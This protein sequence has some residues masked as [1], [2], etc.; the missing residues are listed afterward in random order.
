M[1]LQPHEWF[2]NPASDDLE[3]WMILR[4]TPHQA[5][6]LPK[7]ISFQKLLFLSSLPLNGWC[8]IQVHTSPN[9]Q[10]RPLPFLPTDSC[11]MLWKY[12]RLN[13][14]V[15]MFSVITWMFETEKKGH[16]YLE[17]LIWIFADIYFKNCFISH[18]KAPEIESSLCNV[19]YS[20]T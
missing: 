10:R 3:K 19:I 20:F 15:P 16:W 4:L 13:A 14:T 8:G 17:I 11:S 12:F 18:S 1:T 5:T 6:T 2:K 7:W 9:Q